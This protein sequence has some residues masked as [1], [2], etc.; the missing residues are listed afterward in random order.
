MS[1]LKALQLQ[2]TLARLGL[3]GCLLRMIYLFKQQ[4]AEPGSVLHRKVQDG[5]DLICFAHS[6]SK[7]WQEKKQATLNSLGGSKLNISKE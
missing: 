1:T 2:T 6:K 7:F 3:T 5:P 4:I